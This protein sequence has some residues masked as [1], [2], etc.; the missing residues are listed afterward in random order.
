MIKLTNEFTLIAPKADNNGI[1][2]DTDKIITSLTTAAGGATVTPATG[3]WVDNDQLY[4][5]SN[6]AITV[7]CDG[8]SLDGVTTALSQA[9][10]YLMSDG[11]QLAVSVTSKAGL[12]IYEPEDSQ[13][14]IKWDLYNVYNKAYAVKA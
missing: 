2:I 11:G 7:D 10:R 6:I 13:D 4:K 1:K 9:V 5:D 12:T 8:N 3:Y 14:T